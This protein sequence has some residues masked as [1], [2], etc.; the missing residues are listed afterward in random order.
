MR[1]HEKGGK[2]NQT[3]NS[4]AEH[5]SMHISR[6]QPACAGKALI[7]H[8]AAGRTGVLTD[9]AMHRMKGYRMMQRR[10]A[11]SATR[12]KMPNFPSNRHLRHGALHDSE[13]ISKLKVAGFDEIDF[14]ADACLL[15]L[16]CSGVFK[17]VGCRLGG[18]RP[19]RQLWANW[20]SIT[21]RPT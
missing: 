8:S 17:R 11:D 13:C 10:A 2:H 9:K 1:P 15:H 19:V 12:Q 6:R 5:V 4:E 21:W 20:Q 14:G 18:H 3:P 7:S 16:G